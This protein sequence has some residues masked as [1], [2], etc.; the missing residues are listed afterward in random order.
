MAQAPGSL[1]E[2]LARQ[3]LARLETER[4]CSAHTLRAYA[5]DLRLF[6]EFM[7]AEGKTSVAQVDHLA[8][9]KYL[10]GLKAKS[11]AR[12][13]VARMLASLRSFF[14]FLCREGYC[15]AN[16]VKAVRTP[17]REQRL[18]KFLTTEDVERLLA[19]PDRSTL[20]GKRDAAILETLYSTG[21]RVSELVALNVNDL[22]FL[23]DT[24]LVRG[25]RKKERL[26]LLG[27]FALEALKDYLEARHIRPST[28]GF[29]REPLFLNNRGGRL[30]DRSVRRVLNRAL[31]AANL[32]AKATPHTLRHSFATHMLSRGAD[33]RAVQE[34][35]GHESITTTQVYTHLTPELLNQVYN[36]AHPRAKR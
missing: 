20:D 19:A 16:P 35:L 4:N 32:S 28:A 18:P 8:L 33:L 15:G 14:T 29:S 27:R 23:A 26:C 25:K 9:R 34:L 11:Y 6:F 10:A 24:A 2:G 12:S 3:F 21:A 17:R 13:T 22:D 5:A 31:I 7:A 36:Q 30:T 1:L